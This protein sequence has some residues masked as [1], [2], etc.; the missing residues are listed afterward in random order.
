MANEMKKVCVPVDN[1]LFLGNIIINAA[2]VSI[3][4]IYISA[5]KFYSVLFIAV[6]L[7]RIS[8]NYSKMF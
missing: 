5:V 1:V 4:N 2:K 3:N 8:N 6:D 7:G